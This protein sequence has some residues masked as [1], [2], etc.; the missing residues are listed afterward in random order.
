MRIE[1]GDNRRTALF[2]RPANRFPDH[3]LM[4]AMKTVKVAQCQNGAPQVIGNRGAG[5]EANHSG[6]GFR[7]R[8]S[9]TKE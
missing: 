2:A 1:G 8:V 9:V 4:A 5:I 7:A 3:R 6:T